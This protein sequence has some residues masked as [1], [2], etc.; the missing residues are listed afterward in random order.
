MV[1]TSARVM[2][3]LGRAV[4]V[5]V[6]VGDVVVRAKP[7]N[8]QKP[9]H[10]GDD[11]FPFQLP[12]R[13]KRHSMFNC[14]SVTGIVG[15]IA[16]TPT[17]KDVSILARRRFQGD[18][19]AFSDN[20]FFVLFIFST[21]AAVQVIRYKITV[22]FFFFMVAT[23]FASPGDCSCITVFLLVPFP[24]CCL[25]LKSIV[26]VAF[27]VLVQ[28]AGGFAIV[29]GTGA[30]ILRMLTYTRTVSPNLRVFNENIKSAGIIAC[31][32]TKAEQTGASSAVHGNA[33]NLILSG[34]V[35]DVLEVAH[36]AVIDIQH[37]L[38]TENR[39]KDG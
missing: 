2:V 28:L 39:A 1:V 36:I 29:V 35:D 15:C 13:G 21:F 3:P 17:G 37:L 30:K 9:S 7:G 24:Q 11:F 16:V 26:L 8:R 34:D 31:F 38:C 19:S 22:F 14:Y 27:G 10:T 32:S 4:R 18:W 20:F 5:T 6:D 33:G 25:Y 12:L 23:V